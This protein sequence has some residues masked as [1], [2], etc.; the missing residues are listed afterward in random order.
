[1]PPPAMRDLLGAISP[2]P[3]EGHLVHIG[4]AAVT[5]CMPAYGSQ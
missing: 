2:S 1:M 3:L 5:S 4:A